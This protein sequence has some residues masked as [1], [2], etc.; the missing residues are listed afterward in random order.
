MNFFPSY[1]N[2][3]I[4]VSIILLLG[5]VFSGYLPHEKEK[6]P[7]SGYGNDQ[8]KGDGKNKESLLN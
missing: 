6:S 5:G 8:K 7:G 4:L 2:C 1:S 3:S